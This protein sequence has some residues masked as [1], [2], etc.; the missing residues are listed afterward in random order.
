[1]HS[2]YSIWMTH[3]INRYNKVHEILHA[4]KMKIHTSI[5]TSANISKGKIADAQ[6]DISIL[7]NLRLT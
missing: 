3:N 5:A 6:K 1:M 7:Q 2:F 4:A